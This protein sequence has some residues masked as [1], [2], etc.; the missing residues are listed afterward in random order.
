MGRAVGPN[1]PG[2]MRPDICREYKR[3]TGRKVIEDF[4]YWEPCHKSLLGSG[5]RGVGEYLS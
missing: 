1:G 2:S 3:E 4:A 5:I